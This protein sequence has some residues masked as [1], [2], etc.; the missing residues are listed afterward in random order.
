MLLAPDNN[1]CE[2]ILLT[3]KNLISLNLTVAQK[4][5]ESILFDAKVKSMLLTACLKAPKVATVFF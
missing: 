2:L 3:V 4:L 5:C 1:H